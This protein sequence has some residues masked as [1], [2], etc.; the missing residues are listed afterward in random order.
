MLAKAAGA[1]LFFVCNPEQPHR[2]QRAGAALADFVARLKTVAPEARVLVDEAYFDYADEPG[3]ATAVPL[4]MADPRVV[5]TRTFS[6]VFGM[7]GLRVG[8]A[9]AHPDTL[10]ALRGA[11][12]GR[13]A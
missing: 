11:R 13:D 10:P 6:K 3:Y 12:V 5:V 9:I 8:Y 1:G 2:R 7:A 4:A